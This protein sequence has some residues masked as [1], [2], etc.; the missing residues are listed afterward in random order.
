LEKIKE[1]NGSSG[2]DLSHPSCPWYANGLQ[3][4]VMRNHGINL[5]F[6]ELLDAEEE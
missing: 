6:L 4:S 3:R 2:Y 1:T 5:D